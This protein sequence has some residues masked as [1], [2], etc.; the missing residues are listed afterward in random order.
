MREKAYFLEDIFLSGGKNQHL[1][2]IS[3]APDSFAYIILGTL[4]DNPESCQVGKITPSLQI[5]QKMQHLEI[6]SVTMNSQDTNSLLSNS[7]N[8]DLPISTLALLRD[9]K[10]RK[11]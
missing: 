6:H 2:S 11:D 9:K 4:H 1:L 5:K 8:Y 7:K 3:H 10:K